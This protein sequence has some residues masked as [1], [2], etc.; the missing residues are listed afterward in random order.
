MTAAHRFRTEG[1]R[2][3]VNRGKIYWTRSISSE[4]VIILPKNT[5][6]P[7]AERNEKFFEARESSAS[8]CISRARHDINLPPSRNDR[9]ERPE[10]VAKIREIGEKVLSFFISEKKLP[11]DLKKKPTREWNLEDYVKKEELWRRKLGW[12]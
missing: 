10:L 8:V 11:R 6:K 7:A 12:F 1:F 4:P 3:V 2:I 5:K 9:S